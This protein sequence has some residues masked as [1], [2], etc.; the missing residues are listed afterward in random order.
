MK[1]ALDL[2]K[3][4][5]AEVVLLHAAELPDMVDGAMKVQPDGA[6]APMTLEAYTKLQA[7][8]WMDED[9]AATAASGAGV[10]LRKVVEVGP[11]VDTLL[12]VAAREKAD[13][14]VMGTQGRSGLTR[15]VLGSTAERVVRQS[16]IPVLTVRRSEG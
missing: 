6:K 10:S 1:L 7:E 16:T 15:W 12:A 2:A 3:V 9:C 4:H 13:L 14:I 5:G 11:P 8:G